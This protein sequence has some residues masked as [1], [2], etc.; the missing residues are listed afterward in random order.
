MQTAPPPPHSKLVDIVH[1]KQ[2]SEMDVVGMERK[3]SM[4]DES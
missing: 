2:I 3:K 1:F 4:V